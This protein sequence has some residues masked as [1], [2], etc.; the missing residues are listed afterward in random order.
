MELYLGIDGG[1]TTT[2]A[3]LVEES[4]QILGVGRSGPSNYHNVGLK[5]AA[6]NIE[7]AFEA[8]RA[9][10]GLSQDKVDGAFLGLAGIKSRGDMAR[11]KVALEEVGLSPPERIC[12]VNDLYN[13]HTG[14]LE[15]APGIA[16]IAGTGTHCL[17]R[18]AG[19]QTFL[20][21]GWGW[22]LDDR[23][24]A[25]GL[26]ADALREVV[27]AADKRGPGTRLLEASLA[28]FGL[29][30]AAQFLEHLYVHEWK[31]GR[32]AEFAPVVTQL[33]EEGD[34][35][36]L[37]VVEDGAGALAETIATT[38]A[39]LEFPGGP[40]VVLLGGCVRATDSYGKRVREKISQSCPSARLREPRHDSVYGAAMNALSLARRR[41]LPALS[42]LARLT[43][44]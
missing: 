11:V 33:A 36:A 30:E 3:I 31:P 7:T 35:V 43:S 44:Q 14:G 25:F 39:E 1:G 8:A 4:G 15:A 6:R 42:G 28:F 41:P 5:E 17:G 20:C 29:S 32:I 40:E 34:P 26:A 13:A 9:D 21:G 16:L 2:R 22:F 24:G 19:G 27:R 12:V 18:D 10:A 37:A 38:A 23:G